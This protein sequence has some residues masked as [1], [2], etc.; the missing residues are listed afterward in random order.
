MSTQPLVDALLRS[1]AAC[2]L[3][4]AFVNGKLKSETSY[5]YTHTSFNTRNVVATRFHD[6]HR[7]FLDC[8]I[9]DFDS[10][11]SSNASLTALQND[12][13][14][15]LEQM[16]FEIDQSTVSASNRPPRPQSCVGC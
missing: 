13:S 16:Q 11:N 2:P 15:V 7:F 4:P 6:V 14:L 12:M 10:T 5:T 8:R 9:S 1:C 3:A